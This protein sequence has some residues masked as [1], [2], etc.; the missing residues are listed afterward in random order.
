MMKRTSHQT[1]KKKALDDLDVQKAYDDLEEEFLLVSELIRA[2]KMMGKS[3]K[4]VAK[5]MHTSSS[6]VSR[7]EAGFGRERHSPSLDTLR[8]Y[9]E[10]V[11]CYLSIK[12]V[13]RLRKSKKLGS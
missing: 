6:A 9:A 11:D 5:A 10:A 7:L 3:Q 1:F 2:R 8:R 4:D 12:L 13:P